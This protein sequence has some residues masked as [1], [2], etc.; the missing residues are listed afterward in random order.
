MSPPAGLARLGFPESEFDRV[1]FE[2]CMRIIR[3]GGRVLYGGH[4]R[5]GSRT[6]RMFEFLASA[7]ATGVLKDGPSR[8]KPCLHLLPLSEFRRVSVARLLD[9]QKSFGSFLETRVVLGG[10]EFVTFSRRSDAVLARRNGDKPDRGE[11]LA[12][13]DDLS[14]FLSALPELPEPRALSLMRDAAR[15]LTAARIV[16]GGKR[17][18]LGV[19]GGADRFAGSIPGI[20]EEALLSI[21]TGVPTVVLAAY[22]GAARDV[23]IDL[24]LIGEGLR[25]PFKG[26]TQRGYQEARDQMMRL[27][28]R[29]PIEAKEAMA[30]FAIREDAEDLARD[31]VSWI[32]CRLTPHGACFG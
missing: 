10:D 17:G 14:K 32:A 30:S 26:E 11:R 3:A 31:A 18:D 23:A 16:L 15:R 28:D 8:D 21:E 6:S 9:D 19:E 12:S 27:R 13:A 24:G 5:E 1:M 25:A 2:L 29:L 22:G 7:Y 20:Y 4:L